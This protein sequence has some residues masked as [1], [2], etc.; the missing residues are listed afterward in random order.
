[1]TREDRV[2]TAVATVEDPE[3]AVTLQD[4]GVVRSVQLRADRVEVVL[5]PTRLACPAR[6]EMAR[7]V[8]AAVKAVEPELAVTVRWE[9][10]TWQAADVS[11]HGSQILVQVGYADPKTSA[12][13]PYC[14]SAQ[15]RREGAFGG[16]VCKV[17]F[18][19]QACGSTF[20]ALKGSTSAQADARD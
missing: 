14:G 17:P 6:P 12:R 15:V 1:M 8:E 7:R 13:C 9:M 2:R 10:A 11:A 3:V 16:A 5:R 18:S 4:L 19:C 20:D